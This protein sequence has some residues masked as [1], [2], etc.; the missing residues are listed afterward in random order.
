MLLPLIGHDSLRNRLSAAIASGALPHSLLLHGRAGIGKQRLALWIAEQLLCEGRERP[1]GE[2]RQ[3]RMVLQ[4][5][6]PDLLWVFPRPRPKDSEAA[7]DQV[8]ADLAD[9][10]RARA[11]EHGLYP[12]PPGTEA[13]FVST[14]R[15]AVRLAS[16]TPAMG[17]AKCII[18]GEADRL[19]AQEGNEFAANALLKLLEEPPANTTLILTTSFPG[20]LLPTIRSRCVSVRVAPLSEHAM[21]SWLS[22]EL[23]RKRLD[24]LGV[25]S[26]I[27]DRLR[28]AEG[29][30][31]RLLAL[32]ESHSSMQQARTLLEAAA[33]ANAEQLTRLA[34]AQGA[35]GARG[36]FTDVLEGLAAA[37][38]ERLQDATSRSDERGALG[39]ARAIERVEDAKAIAHGNVNPQ[40]IAAHLLTEI[41]ALLR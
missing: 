41:S 32:G 9:A 16:I 8:R 6:H 5:N 39:A 37:L 40:L 4:L 23:V 19:V 2:C 1:C 25:A 28:L 13:I 11:E 30:P 26:S 17:R 22:E 10:A 27:Q 34:L 24:G 38:G 35:S 29:A 33:S 18:V 36:R 15:A 20:A 7:P 3:C 21:R 31:G 12:A 14:I